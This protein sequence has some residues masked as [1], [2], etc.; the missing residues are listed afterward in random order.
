MTSTFTL[1]N[2]I[3]TKQ[4][5]DRNSHLPESLKLQNEDFRNNYDWQHDYPDIELFN[6]SL[7]IKEQL[8]NE[9]DRLQQELKEIVSKHDKLPNSCNN[10]LYNGLLITSTDHLQ[11]E[12]QSVSNEDDRQPGYNI[13]YDQYPYPY[14]DYINGTEQL[15]IQELNETYQKIK[16]ELDKLVKRIEQIKPINLA[17]KYVYNKLVFS[18]YIVLLIIMTFK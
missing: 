16:N 9:I 5:G 3:S 18:L 17:N 6:S 7:F 14:D 15:I 13:E 1:A 4:E 2:V 8:R 12:R 10:N 11:H